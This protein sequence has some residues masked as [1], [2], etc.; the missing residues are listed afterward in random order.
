MDPLLLALGRPLHCAG[1]EIH[2][3]EVRNEL[4]PDLDDRGGRFERDRAAGRDDLIRDQ[5][6]VGEDLD[7]RPDQVIEPGDCRRRCAVVGQTA[8]HKEAI[9]LIR[10]PIEFRQEFNKTLRNPVDR[11]ADDHPELVLVGPRD[12]GDAFDGAGHRVTVPGVDLLVLL[13]GHAQE[14]PVGPGGPNDREGRAHVGPI[15]NPA[16]RDMLGQEREVSG[17]IAIEVVMIGELPGDLS[18]VLRK[19]QALHEKDDVPEV[20]RR[21][22]GASVG[23]LLIGL[24]VGRRERLVRVR[25][26]DRPLAVVGPDDQVRY[27]RN[28]GD[29]ID[30]LGGERVGETA[31]G[32]GPR[33]KVLV[34]SHGRPPEG[35]RIVERVGEPHTFLVQGDCGGISPLGREGALGEIGRQ[36]VVAELALDG[37]RDLGR[38]RVAYDLDPSSVFGPTVE[39]L[40]VNG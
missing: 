24:D 20:D 26:L 40:A 2:R 32:V 8:I 10:A 12:H 14:R 13:V 3:L 11:P 37:N 31:I 33:R 38:A 34:G 6:A 35:L 23:A 28:P 29:R 19:P 21:D 25:R 9:L 16:L 7:R 1:L 5:G 17:H 4:E 39:S 36:D 30:L 15:D 18:V 22:L 27:G